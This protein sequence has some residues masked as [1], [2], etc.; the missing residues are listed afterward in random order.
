MTGPNVLHQGYNSGYNLAEAVNFVAPNWLHATYRDLRRCVCIT[1][2]PM[3]EPYILYNR[4][5]TV[6]EDSIKTK[7]FM[8]S[9]CDWNYIRQITL[10]CSRLRKE[11][12]ES[13]FNNDSK[14]DSS[15]LLC[16]FY[17]K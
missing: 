13:F 14:R 1:T 5:I 10:L 16:F 3:M 15:N 9:P 12:N 6:L 4:Y 2:A 7:N 11:L 17:L 8:N